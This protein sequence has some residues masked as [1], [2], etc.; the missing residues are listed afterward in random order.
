[1]QSWSV[2]QSVSACVS[3]SATFA[4]L[5]CRSIQGAL[6]MRELAGPCTRRSVECCAEGMLLQ[7]ALSHYCPLAAGAKSTIAAAYIS[8]VD[9][10]DLLAT[11]Q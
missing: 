11:S 6:L 4:F 3:L 10:R 9:Q 8:G 1:M 5:S 2:F 7:H